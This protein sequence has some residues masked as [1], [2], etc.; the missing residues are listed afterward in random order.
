MTVVILPC[1]QF[2]GCQHA[3]S[4]WKSFLGVQLQLHTRFRLAT[5]GLHRLHEEHRHQWWRYLPGLLTDA[6]RAG[7]VGRMWSHRPKLRLKFLPERGTVRGILVWPQLPLQATILRSHMQPRWG[8][9]AT[10][11]GVFICK[12]VW[13]V[14]QHNV[15]MAERSTSRKDPPSGERQDA[16]CH[17]GVV[18][19]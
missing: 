11:D 3:T 4:S 16:H 6:P 15:H 10:S 17:P 9:H 19:N 13:G 7:V 5:R 2:S 8:V 1:S 18:S 12:S 14:H